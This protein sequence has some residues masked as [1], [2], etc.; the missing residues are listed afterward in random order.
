MITA[1]INFLTGIII[2]V[3]SG[4]GYVGVALLMGI[5]SAAI[6][7]PSE[8]IMPFSGYLASTGRFTLWGLALAGGIGSMIG[9]AVTYWIGR[10]GGRPL[11]ERYGKYVLISNRDLELADKFFA[12][13]GLMATFIGRVLPVFRTFISVPA[14]IARVSFWPFLLYSFLGSVIWSWLL[15]YIGMRLGPEWVQLREKA[16]GLDYVILALGLIGAAWWVWRHL[17]HRRLDRNG[18]K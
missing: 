9:S 3:I 2:D 17:K 6:P 8:I 16:H 15:A 4:S 18:M 5:E 14:G 13:Y 1:I 7:L 10:Y 11:I 12:R